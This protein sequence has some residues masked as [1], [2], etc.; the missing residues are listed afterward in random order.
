MI[1][2]AHTASVALVCDRVLG[3]DHHAHCCSQTRPPRPHLTNCAAVCGQLTSSCVEWQALS[4]GHSR[5]SAPRGLANA[6]PGFLGSTQGGKTRFLSYDCRLRSSG[7]L[8]S[9]YYSV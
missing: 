7:K 5:H 3:G 6:S 1:I 2:T 4:V 8:A 9:F